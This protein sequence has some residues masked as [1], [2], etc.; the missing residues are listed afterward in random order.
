MT[1]ALLLISF[2]KHYFTKK[3]NKTIKGVK[4]SAKAA[5]KLLEYFRE[6]NLP[7]IHII[8][9]G[10]PEDLSAEKLQ[11]YELL[12]PKNQES[13]MV[14]EN[15]NAF[16]DHKLYQKLK[17]LKVDHL[18]LAGLTVEKQILTT[19]MA[20]REL[21]YTCTVAQ[22][23]CAATNLKLE[24]EKIEDEQV[25]KVTMAILLNAG[26]EVS[27]AKHFIKTEQK[28]IKKLRKAEAKQLAIQEAARDA[29]QAGS[30]P[31]EK[32]KSSR[33]R[34]KKAP[35][36]PGTEEGTLNKE[37]TKSRANSKAKATKKIVPQPEI[38]TGS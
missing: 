35:E 5:F 24:G 28:K 36:M 20:A 1:T 25:H 7:V 10:K 2:Q 16:S 22:D 38:E 9:T 12:E 32:P 14:T 8:Q 33:K 21:A 37:P 23:A 11:P 3:G 30:E 4:K 18:L 6:N 34:I 27:T 29:V 15:N 19:V 26:I 31:T 17:N 13:I